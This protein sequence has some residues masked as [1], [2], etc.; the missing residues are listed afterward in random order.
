MILPWTRADFE[1][2]TGCTT[3]TK[4]TAQAV[5]VVAMTMTRRT[6]GERQPGAHLTSEI[7]SKSL[8]VQP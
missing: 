3:A 6:T 5:A 2:A 8:E 7:E 4:K 1:P